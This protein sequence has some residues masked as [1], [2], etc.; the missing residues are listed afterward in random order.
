ML[1]WGSESSGIGTMGTGG[2]IVSPK[3]RTCTPCT[4]QVKDAAYVISLCKTTLTT[5]LCK[6]CTN[7]YPPL[8]KTFRRACLNLPTLFLPSAITALAALLT[9]FS[10]DNLLH[11]S[12]LLYFV[13]FKHF[14]LHCFDAVGWV[15]GRAS[16]L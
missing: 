5:R 16:G 7:L 13:A 15:A 6:V 11:F 1:D 14:C 2:Y 8:T 10:I 9:L 4:P 12:I 3:F